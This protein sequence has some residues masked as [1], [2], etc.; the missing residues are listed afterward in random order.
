MA[1]RVAWKPALWMRCFT[2]GGVTSV[3]LFYLS[4][5]RYQTR[6]QNSEKKGLLTLSCLSVRPHGK[7][8]HATEG[9]SWNLIFQ[10]FPKICP[11][12]IL[13]TVPCIFCYF[14]KWPTNAQL[15]HK[16]SH[17]SY[18]FRHYRV[19]F[20]ELLINTLPSYTSMSNAVVG[21][22]IYNFPYVYNWFYIFC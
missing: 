12:I 18:M 8:R 13:I 21:N 19:V 11:E 20:R 14:V 1:R 5:I 4:R 15:F 6:S 2:W 16:L 17:S 10:H 3:L 9:F 22:T 7:T